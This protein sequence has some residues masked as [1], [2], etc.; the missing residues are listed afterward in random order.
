MERSIESTLS[1]AGC[2]EV[3]KLKWVI[4][5][6]F[7]ATAAVTT[8]IFYSVFACHSWERT[9]RLWGHAPQQYVFSFLIF[10]FVSFAVFTALY[11]LVASVGPQLQEPSFA[12]KLVENWIILV[13]LVLI[14]ASIVTIT[15]Y[16]SAAMSPDKLNPQYAEMYLASADSLTLDFSSQ[17]SNKLE[18]Y[19]RQRIASARREAESIRLKLDDTQSPMRDLAA[20]SPAAQLQIFQSPKLQRQL[21]LLSQPMQALTMLQLFITLSV[22][23]LSLATIFATWCA[24]EELGYDGTNSPQLK[25]VID[26]LFFSV[27]AF[28]S[29]PICYGQFRNQTE[30]LVGTGNW[31]LSDIFA[32]ATV[33]GALIVLRFLD[34]ANRSLSLSAVGR[35]IPLMVV[36]ASSVLVMRESTLMRQLIGSETKM[37]TQVILGLILLLIGAGAIFSLWPKK[38]L[39][40]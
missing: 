7:I 6:S 33:M 27:L 25:A 4:A 37:G 20:L 13:L 29:F 8:S 17:E 31:I 28:A 10:P 15:V 21:G 3:V 35:F 18:D 11:L 9:M 23:L 12:K 22:G 40:N 2:K 30:Y 34:P 39:F 24:A 36:G 26:A 1:L 32:T 38:S 5:A 14:L 16:L 19:R